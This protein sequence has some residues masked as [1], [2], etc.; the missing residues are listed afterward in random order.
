M[1]LDY[2]KEHVIV[3]ALVEIDCYS[4]AAMEMVLLTGLI[5]SKYEHVRQGGGGPALGWFQMEPATHDDIWRHFLGGTRTLDIVDGLRSMTYLHRI[6]VA[7]ELE[8]NP[9]YGAAMCRV[10]YLRDPRKLPK[11]GDRLAQAEYWKVVYNTHKGK[12]N[13]GKALEIMTE[14]GL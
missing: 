12:G 4:D 6:G 3:P 11:A 10:H 5:E 7:K 8:V 14:Y 2:I 13:V 1:K 9:W